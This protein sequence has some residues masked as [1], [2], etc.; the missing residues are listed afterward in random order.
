MVA[1][2]QGVIDTFVRPLYIYQEATKTIIVTNPNYNPIDDG[3]GQNQ[4]SIINTPNFTL[5]S[6]RVLYDKQQEWSFVRPFAGRGPD[7]GQLKLK[8][9]ITRSVRLKVD[10][11]GF[12][13][14]QT[15]KKI[16]LD[17]LYFDLE[18]VARPHGLF[19]VETYTFYFVRSM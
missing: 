9:Q 18:S 8:D 17:G 19:G 1:G 5:I 12:V 4:T 2:I 7:E 10:Y 11:S 14:L 16:Q 6:G 3:Y 15:A 13:L